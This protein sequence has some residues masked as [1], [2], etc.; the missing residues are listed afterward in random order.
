MFGRQEA[1]VGGVQAGRSPVGQ[2]NKRFMDAV[3]EDVEWAAERKEEDAE[4]L[5]RQVTW[6]RPPLKKT[7]HRTNPWGW[8][9][10]RRCRPSRKTS[11]F[12]GFGVWQF[13]W[14]ESDEQTLALCDKEWRAT[15]RAHGPPTMWGHSVAGAQPGERQRV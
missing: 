10:L 15:M 6:L 14:D 3:N 4:D 2:P 12:W 5:W 11:C 7:A 8:F 13:L 9:S 1:K